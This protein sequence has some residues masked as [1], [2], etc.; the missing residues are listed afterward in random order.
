MDQ[1]DD[2]DADALAVAADEAGM[3]VAVAARIVSR[4]RAIVE[5]VDDE[6]EWRAEMH[7]SG[8][9]G[10]CSTY[11]AEGCNIQMTLWTDKGGKSERVYSERRY[12]AKGYRTFREAVAALKGRSFRNGPLCPSPRQSGE[13]APGPGPASGP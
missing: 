2:L 3:P 6:P 10:G 1:G 13:D 8:A 11:V 7:M 12:G 4:Y 5:A 9:F